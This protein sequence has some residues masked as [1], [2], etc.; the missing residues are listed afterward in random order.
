MA[1]FPVQTKCYVSRTSED[2]GR[3]KI[4]AR[5]K[6]EKVGEGKG[7]AGARECL[8]TNPTPTN[9]FTGEFIFKD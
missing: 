1:S 5:A 8:Q 3:P 9:F 4:G 6:K 2:S 7:A